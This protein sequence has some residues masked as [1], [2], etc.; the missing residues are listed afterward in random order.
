MATVTWTEPA[1]RDV[2]DIASFIARD[3]P[4]YARK[5]ASR[6]LRAGRRLARQPQIGWVVPEFE[7]ESIREI[8]VGPYRVIYRID[9]DNCFI[10]AVIHGSRDLSR[11]IDPGEASQGE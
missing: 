5:M 11:R 1:L 9:G 4:S 10:I 3:S 8:L 6:I 2:V 7:L